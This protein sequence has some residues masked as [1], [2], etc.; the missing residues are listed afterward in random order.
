MDPSNVTEGYKRSYLPM[1]NQLH[2]R[3]MIKEGLVS[4]TLLDNIL[5]AAAIYKEEG[6]QI[7]VVQMNEPYAALTGISP[8]EEDMDRFADH[9]E[10]RELEKLRGLMR[11]ADTHALGGSE[12]T[13]RFRR[14]D[15]ETIEPNM[16]IFL[17]YSFDQ[18]RIYLSAMG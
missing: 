8:R 15:G 7:S 1:A 11:Q 2:F 10:E 18:H 9:L 6:G 12:G 17:L 5:R 3:E 16:R 4:E 14:A 13:L